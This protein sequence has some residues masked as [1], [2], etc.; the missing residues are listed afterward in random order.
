MAEMLP[1]RVEIQFDDA[2]VLAA[3]RVV[4]RTMED[5]AEDFPY[6]EDV[7]NAV[8][9]VNYLMRHVTVAAK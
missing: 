6:R 1:F 7:K 3:L 9:A 8:K 4:N 5:V 2:K